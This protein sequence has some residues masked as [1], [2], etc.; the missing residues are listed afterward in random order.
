MKY[1]VLLTLV[2]I[3]LISSFKV[4]G[5]EITNNTVAIA[6]MLLL[7]ALFSDL[8]EF[9]FWGLSGKKKEEE[10]K[11]LVGSPII[12]EDTE[13]KPS[14]YKLK[15]AFKEDSPDQM[16]NLKDNFLAVSYDIERML[17]II[18]RA[19]RRSTEETALLDPDAVLHYLE[20]EEFLTP[21]ACESIEQL[22]DI[23][24]LLIQSN[25][26][27]A[28]ETLEASMKLALP[29]HMTLKDWLDESNKR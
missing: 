29:I 2:G 26:T 24:D 10:L 7:L 19:I 11:K 5:A 9:N 27:I 14:A 8:K 21:E 28:T 20:D 25:T 12:S 13:E 3:L 18:V 22:R 1:L 17:R 16:G 15:K 6:V 23:R 4:L